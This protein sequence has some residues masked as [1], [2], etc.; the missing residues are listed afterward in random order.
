MTFRCDSCGR[1]RRAEDLR[2]TESPTMDL[3]GYVELNDRVECV[4]CIHG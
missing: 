2:L 4:E 1:F 3:G